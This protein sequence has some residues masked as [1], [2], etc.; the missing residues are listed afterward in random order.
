MFILVAIVG[1]AFASCKKEDISS[2]MNSTSS[3]DSWVTT[4]K[5]VDIEGVM[6]NQITNQ[7]TKQVIFKQIET[8]HDNNNTKAPNA[9]PWTY[10]ARLDG[11]SHV[12]CDGLRTKN[13]FIASDGG[14]VIEQGVEVPSNK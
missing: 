5:G 13:C 8:R 9:A 12:Q 3:K 11:N 4:L 7:I 14:V 10:S 2:K 1:L 6:C